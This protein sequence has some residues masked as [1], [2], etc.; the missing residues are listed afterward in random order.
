[1]KLSQNSSFLFQVIKIQRLFRRFLARKQALQM[2]LKQ[3]L[4]EDEMSQE[5]IDENLKP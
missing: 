5:D 4:S 1:L 2:M 3:Q